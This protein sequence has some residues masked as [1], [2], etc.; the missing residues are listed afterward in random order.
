MPEGM[1]VEIAHKLHEGGERGDRG[2][3]LRRHE[4]IIEILEAV[5]LA[6]VA[7]ATAWSGYQ[8]AKWDGREALLYGEASKYR[9]QGDELATLAG[10]DRLYDITTFDA[11]LQAKAG[12]QEPLADLFERRF[13]GEYR[14]AFEA[15]LATDPLNNPDAPPGPIFMPEYHSAKADE[16]KELERRASET[17]DRGT[18]ARRIADDYVR[19]TVRLAAVLFLI[20]VSQRFEVRGVRIGLM[21]VAAVILATGVFQLTTA[22]HL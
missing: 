10:Q 8:S 1:N 11:W 7:V 16:A 12:G 3:K 6:I 18:E 21:S 15:W 2:G 13:R 19:I 22:P 20:A 9:V 14:V 17:F 4:R 5:V